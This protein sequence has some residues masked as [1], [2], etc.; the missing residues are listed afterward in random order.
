[1]SRSAGFTL[2]ELMIVAVIV[3]ILAAIA[4]PAYQ[5]YVMRSRRTDAF[6]VLTSLSQAQERW[7]SNNPSYADNLA[8]LL[9]DQS[10]ATVFLSPDKHYAV[11]M[12]PYAATGVA[13]YA[14]GYQITAT[15]ASGD[16]QTRDSACSSIYIQV[17]GGNL[18]YSS[19]TTNPAAGLCWPQ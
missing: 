7:R 12:A 17:S 4:V 14:V 16:T 5:N 8:T 19:P 15:P 9:P 3:G 1:M 2:I 10:A 6:N 11:T 13:S 18:T